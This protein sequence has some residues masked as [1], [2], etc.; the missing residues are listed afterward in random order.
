VEPGV[1][2]AEAVEAFRALRMP[3]VSAG[4]VNLVMAFGAELWRAVAPAEAPAD[5]ASFA[6]VTGADGR[7]GPCHPA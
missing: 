3:D 1:S 7:G 5:L 2:A 6:P 4:G